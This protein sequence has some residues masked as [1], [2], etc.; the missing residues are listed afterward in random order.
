MPHPHLI[1][2]SAWRILYIKMYSL[3]NRVIRNPI[4]RLVSFCLLLLL[5]PVSFSYGYLH[6]HSRDNQQTPN[7]SSLIVKFLPEADPYAANARVSRTTTAG[8]ALSALNERYHVTAMRQLTPTAVGGNATGPLAGVY[9]LSVDADVDPVAM[10]D[11]YAALPGVAYVEPDYM[12]E[13]Y[14]QPNDRF[15]SHQ[16]GLHN[17]AQGHY[18]IVRL[19]GGEND[20]VIITN[21]L[22]D[23]DINAAEVYD[24]PPDQTVISIVAI[25]DSGVDIDH[26]D[27]DG[28]VWINPRE[29]AGNG[30]DDDNNGYV[31][32][33]YG[34]DYSSIDESPLPED[35]DPTDEHGHG[36][37]IAGIISAATGN[38]IGVAGVSPST[39]IMALKILPWALVSKIARAV[40][41]AADNGADVINMS[42]GLVFTSRMLEDAFAYAESKGVILCAASGNKGEIEESYPAVSPHTIAV[43]ASD[44]SDHVAYFSSYGDHLHLCAPGLSILSL[45]A[46]GTDMYEE[47]PGDEPRVHIIDSVYYIASGTSMACPY[48]VGVAAYL[49][50]VSPGL[51]TDLVR[52][53]ME[54]TAKDIVSPYGGEAAYP[55]WDMYSGYGR[56]DLRA[57][58][59]AAP[60]VRAKITTPLS[61]QIVSGTVAIAGI[62][63]GAEFQN[64]TLD[65]GNGDTPITWTDLDVSATSKTE[66]PLAVWHTDPLPAGKYTVRLRVNESNEHRVTV[67]AINTSL[68]Q[69]TV[70]DSGDTV[71]EFVSIYGSAYCPGFRRAILEYGHGA[72]PELWQEITAVGVPLYGEYIAAWYFDGFGD[73]L[74]SL[75]WSVYD[76]S[77]MVQADTSVVY[78]RSVFSTGQS[79]KVPLHHRPAVMTTYGDFDGDGSNEILVG[80][81]TGILAF[82]PDGTA[83]TEGLPQFPVNSYMVPMAV[84]RINDDDVDDLVA[85]GY[86]PLTLYGF[87]G[88]GEPFSYEL[89][90]NVQSGEGL[91][92]EYTVSKVF[93]RDIN[94]DGLD[95]IHVFL[96]G[97]IYSRAYVFTSD[98]YLI[99]EM[100]YLQD[101]LPVD[102]TGNNWDELYIYSAVDGALKVL[103]YSGRVI[104]SVLIRQDETKLTM[105]G[106]SA[107]DIDGDGVCELLIHGNYPATGFWMYAFESDG[108]VHPVSGWPRNL[109]MDAYLVP[110]SPIFGDFDGDQELEYFTTYYDFSESYILAWEADGTPIVSDNA[111]GRFA[112]LP[113]PSILSILLLADMDD[114]RI[115][116]VVASANNDVFALFRVQR[117]YAWNYRAEIIDGFPFVASQGSASSYRFT[118]TIG[119]IN[120]DGWVDMIMTTPDSNLIFVNFPGNTYDSTASPATSWRYNRRLNNI[121][122]LLASDSPTGIDDTTGNL[123]TNPTLMANRPNPFNPTTEI[124]FSLPVRA[125][126]RMTVYNILGQ[127]VRTL[128]DEPKAPGL[129]HIIWDG[130]DDNGG[131]VAS[132]MYLYRITAGSFVDVK[133]MLLLK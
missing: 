41:Y 66:E 60:R 51:K 59:D 120:R 95:E 29:I 44:D 123:P 62:A 16:W 6:Q 128:L 28:Q 100:N 88:N 117:P 122:P 3:I 47:S 57:A 114:D 32:D 30:I 24:N 68:A 39:R 34:W 70:P 38:G 61:G 27:L 20:K 132:G 11:D 112:R 94:G 19:D 133:K 14:D 50:A 18:H 54:N 124:A 25:I 89:D 43:G 74:Y 22:N 129:H 86:N 26:P 106:M 76:E 118:P 79:W 49:R 64:Y 121:G 85:L 97:G 37:H 109:D 130:T 105:Q 84:G 99:S 92:A 10:Q 4:G 103:D 83:K 21:G 63:D 33:M 115:P 116:D 73:G 58:L 65:Y 90:A 7:S 2:S 87:P 107:Q 42:F 111:D 12:V 131:E 9:L 127:R 23:A 36:T 93:L 8:A 5:L 126:V 91:L 102:L 35:N 80:T 81:K 56:V 48:V 77:G 104:D 55:G 98:G 119:D 31:D 75:R 17:Q 125:H 72:E 15:Y 53:L 101:Y 46:E 71:S 40:V 13:L 96:Y 82:N 45:R 78:V 52:D 1:A 113:N 69:L 108:G 110:T 67:H